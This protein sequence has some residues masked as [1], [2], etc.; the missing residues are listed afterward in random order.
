MA[1]IEGAQGNGPDRPD[2]QEQP[3]KEPVQRVTQ[4]YVRTNKEV[5]EM[6]GQG[7]IILEALEKSDKP[8]NVSE[9]T[10]QVKGKFETRQ[11]PER[12]V[13]FYLSK[14]KREGIVNVAGGEKAAA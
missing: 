14:W 13:G 9:L 7:R 10:E 8:L 6:K 4:R 1:K 5:K 12:V 2:P 11:D 3:A